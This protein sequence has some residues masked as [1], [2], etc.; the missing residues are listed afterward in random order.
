MRKVVAHYFY[1]EFIP[2]GSCDGY[3]LTH[4]LGSGVDVGPMNF[5]NFLVNMKFGEAV[6]GLYIFVLLRKQR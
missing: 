4:H 1:K 5:C 2:E 3:D 6:Q